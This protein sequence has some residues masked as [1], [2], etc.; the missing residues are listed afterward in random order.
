M[1]RAVFANH[2]HEIIP[3]PLEND[4]LVVDKLRQSGAKMV[5]VTPSHQFP[6]GIVMPVQN[7]A[8][9]LQWAYENNGYIVEDDYDS[10]FRHQGQPIP[11]LKAMDTGD[12]VI[13]LGTF[14]KSFFPGARL[15][16]MVLPELLAQSY[17]KEMQ[18]YNQSV[19]RSYR[20][21]YMCL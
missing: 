12:R 2:G 9:L 16:Y 17:K 3:I 20:R 10:E 11:A 14:S 7:R 13:Y 1:V 5:Y 6:I 8:K 4:G 18:S 21:Q 19:Y 15:S